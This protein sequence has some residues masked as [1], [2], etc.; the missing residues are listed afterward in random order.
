MAEPLVIV[1]TGFAGYALLRALRQRDRHREIH[2][3]GADEAAAYSKDQL[4]AGLAHRRDADELVIATA[5]Q[6]AYRFEATITPH[7]RVLAID[8]ASRMLRTDNPA[9]AE[10]AWSQLVL[11]TGAES[12]RPANVRGSAAASVLT[13]GSLAEYAYLRSELAGRRRVAVVGG[14]IRGCELAE[15]LKRGGCE[16]TLLESD[17]QLLG[18]SV[19]ALCAERIAAALAAAGVRIRTEDG[20][21]RIDQGMS[22]LHVTMLGGKPLAVDVV[23]AA[24]PTRP[25]VQLAQAAGL[26]VAAG[27]VVDA[28]LRTSAETIHAL[29]G[30]AEFEGRVFELGE[31]IEAGAQAL[32]DVL[33][34]HGARMR[35]KARVRRLNLDCCAVAIC[36]PPPVAGEWHES[37]TARGV[38]ALFHDRAGTLRGFVL[39]GDPAGESGRLLGRVAR[40]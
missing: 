39:V 21:Q 10:Q 14:S 22:E 7:R 33:A 40:S 31:D 2:M 36:E 19:P 38:R 32:A 37:A 23:V 16:V 26:D 13:V 3:V 4:P 28:A 20:I 6:M 8:P 25:R 35:W 18:G 5:E 30:C 17:P 34:G 29:G 11:A 12:V 15:S 1:G 27:I 9:Q 24:L